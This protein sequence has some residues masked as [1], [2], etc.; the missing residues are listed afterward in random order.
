MTNENFPNVIF[1]KDSLLLSGV[2][3]EDEGTWTCIASNI[4]GSDS[5]L[6]TQMNQILYEA[7]VG[8]DLVLN[9]AIDANPQ[10]RFKWFFEN[11]QIN[12]FAKSVSLDELTG[13]LT[14]ENVTL[15]N[16]GTDPRTQ[17]MK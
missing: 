1:A 2:S 15:S 8:Q 6:M 17:N 7:T 9:C 14:V 13:Q 10:P 4:A 12:T 11:N 3:R 5:I 16:E